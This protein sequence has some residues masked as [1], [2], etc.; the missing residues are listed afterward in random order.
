MQSLKC[1]LSLVQK[2][3]LLP[4]CFQRP[5]IE[6]G[7]ALEIILLFPE[8]RQFFLRSLYVAPARLEPCELRLCPQGFVQ[9]CHDFVAL[10]V[11]LTGKASERRES[12]RSPKPPFSLVK[13]RLRLL[14]LRKSP[15][16]REER[17]PK[18]EA[19]ILLRDLS[20]KKRGLLH[21]RCNPYVQFVEAS[22]QVRHAGGRLCAHLIRYAL[23]LFALG[24]EQRVQLHN[25]SAGDLGHFVVDS[26]IEELFENLNPLGGLHLEKLLKLSLR[27]QHDLRKFI[28]AQAQKL[29]QCLIRRRGPV[30]QKLIGSRLIHPVQGDLAGGLGFFSSPVLSSIGE[31]PVYFPPGRRGKK[32]EFDPGLAPC[33]GKARDEF[34]LEIAPPSHG[35]A[36]QCVRDRIED[37]GFAGACLAI[38]EEKI[39]ESGKIYVLALAVGAEVLEGE[40]QRSH[41]SSCSASERSDSKAF[42]I[43]SAGD[44]SRMHRA[45]EAKSPQGCSVARIAPRQ[46]ERLPILCI[47]TSFHRQARPR[48]LR[49]SPFFQRLVGAP[50]RDWENGQPAH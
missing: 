47:K 33:G 46:T 23:E 4:P 32:F 41:A 2:L 5:L 8:R 20:L 24:I 50:T 22:L 49:R 13:G 6:S 34:T 1:F 10:T 42:T 26:H 48:T 27:Q 3:R 38:D 36:V 45:K 15:P 7:A 11:D 25:L 17:L 43:S 30:G 39:V 18:G 37:G 9:R 12:L 16:C 29:E 28:G 35:L 14:D 19:L 40:C 44:S 21:H 31:A